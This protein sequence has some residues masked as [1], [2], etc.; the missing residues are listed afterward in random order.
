MKTALALSTLLA[1]TS[2]SANANLILSADGIINYG[3]YN[4][5]EIGSTSYDYFSLGENIDLAGFSFSVEMEI[6]DELLARTPTSIDP[7]Y[8]RWVSEIPGDILISYIVNNQRYQIPQEKGN[9]YIPQFNISTDGFRSAHTQYEDVDSLGDTYLHKYDNG[10]IVETA[11]GGSAGLF[12]RRKIRD[13][14]T[15]ETFEQTVTSFNGTLGAFTERQVKVPE[16]Y[17][18]ALLGVGLVGLMLNRRKI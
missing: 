10:G 4:C 6:S 16:P 5:T 3:C 9:L 8:T 17:S 18:I 14:E 2:I 15:G 1:T 12:F 13:F 11:D 7:L